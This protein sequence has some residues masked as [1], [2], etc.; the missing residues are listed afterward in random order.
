VDECSPYLRAIRLLQRW[1]HGILHA[2]DLLL[3]PLTVE[4]NLRLG[5]AEVPL[6]RGLH[7][8][9]SELN[10]SIVYGIGGA[11]RDCV[12]RANGGVGGDQGV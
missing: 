6:L 5:E 2:L 7:F 4:G 9:T 10:F 11:R 3:V 1:V 8:L 12:S